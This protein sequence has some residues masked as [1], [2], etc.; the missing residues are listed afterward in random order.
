MEV[1]RNKIDNNDDNS[2]NNACDAIM[3]L[4]MITVIGFDSSINDS[5][6][7]KLM[8]A[9]KHYFSQKGILLK[10]MISHIPF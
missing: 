9:R 1:I 10:S 8:V 3:V 4:I 5:I 7:K 6:S 2:G